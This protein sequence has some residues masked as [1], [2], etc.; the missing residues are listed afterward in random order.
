MIHVPG[1]V[2]HVLLCELHVLLDVRTELDQQ[3]ALCDLHAEDE[4][5][6]EL[7]GDQQV[8]DEQHGDQLVDGELDGDQLVDGELDGELE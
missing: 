6:G 7:D 2:E 5:L 8:H 1:S 4:L 3:R